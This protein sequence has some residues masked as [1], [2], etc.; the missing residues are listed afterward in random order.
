MDLKYYK[1]P[2]NPTELMKENESLRTSSL[3]ESIAQNIML[4]II[5]KK[6]ESR[7]DKNYGNEV[8]D[9][10][11]DNAVSTSKWEDVFI[12]CMKEQIELYEPRI[13]DIV[14][15][16]RIE[17]IEKNYENRKQVEIKKKANIVV[18]AKLEET[19]EDFHFST[20]LFLSPMSFN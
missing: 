9:L 10:E 13:K 1:L 6:G 16:A 17:Y 2:F 11:F 19:G 5:T 14:I 7:V 18:H 15:K 20:G 3:Y 8:W 12:Q 4:I